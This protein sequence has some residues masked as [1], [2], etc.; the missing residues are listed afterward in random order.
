MQRTDFVT[1][2]EDVI[3]NIKTLYAYAQSEKVEYRDWAE[4]RYAQGTWFVVEKIENQLYFAPSRF[5]G[6]KNNTLQK[7]IDAHGDGT[8]TNRILD[9]KLKLYKPIRKSEGLLL[10]FQSFLMSLGIQKKPKKNAKFFIP[11]NIELSD[12]VGEW[13]GDL[14]YSSS[15]EYDY[16]IELLKSNKNLVLTGAPGTGKTH[17]AKEIAKRLIGGRGSIL[18]PLDDFESKIY[19]YIKVGT[20][21]NSSGGKRMY[22]VSKIEEKKV[23][24]SGDTINGYDITFN[25]IESAYK[26]RLWEGGQKNGHDPYSAALAKVIYEKESNHPKIKDF[27]NN[28]EIL[29]SCHIELVQFHPSY[30]Y[31]DFVE[32]LRPTPPDAN[33]NI[34][35]NRV[36]GTF[37]AFCKRAIKDQEKTFVFIIDEINRGEISKIFGELFFSI[38]PGYRGK[39]GRVKTQYQNLI[40]DETDSFYDGFYV[41]ENVYIIGTM[42]DI[43]RSVESMDFA[44]RRRFAWQEIKANEN[45]G[46]LEELDSMKG[47]VIQKMQRLN[48]AIEETEGLNSSYHI[49]G[50]YFCKLAQYLNEEQD[51]IQEAYK[52]LWETHL[53]GVL[54]EY[55]RGMANAEENLERL[56]TVYFEEDENN[57]PE[58]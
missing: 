22:D 43:D 57:Q 24:V 23:Y 26:R 15:A 8:E 2:R 55:L 42:N 45:T 53:K 54:F 16:Y 36:D 38:D 14:F 28:E 11:R 1:S 9:G 7:H 17:L 12:W 29:I 18:T 40:T 52:Q 30:D 49:G 27:Q 25:E 50:A 20:K 5:V 39:K 44:M 19:K 51:N 4:A 56:R 48:A 13:A 31:T 34:G 58:R 21:V 35:F 10:Q 47:E 32:G 33:G 3:K 37:K 41:P 46:M 6:Y